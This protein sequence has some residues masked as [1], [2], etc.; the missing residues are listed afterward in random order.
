[1]SRHIRIPFLLDVY[2]VTSSHLILQ[3]ANNPD[4]DRNYVYR[5]PLINRLII[6]RI[7]A[8]MRV[9][10][11]I[12]DDP[13]KN[14]KKKPHLKTIFNPGN[15][16]TNQWFPSAD[17]LKDPTRINNRDSLE[18]RLNTG[19][20][21]DSNLIQ[22][23]ARYIRNEKS[24]P[25]EQIAQELVGRLFVGDFTANKQ[26]IKYADRIN[27]AINSFNPLR[28]I[29]WIATR[30]LDR[31]HSELLISM[32]GDLS[33]VHAISIAFHNITKSI[34]IMASLYAG[35]HPDASLDEIRARAMHAPESVLRQSKSVSSSQ[36]GPLRPGTLV[37]FS[38]HMA[39][40]RHL[41]NRIAFM[42]TSPSKCPAHNAVPN[43]LD[44]IW[45]E[46][47]L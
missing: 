36:I 6:A 8:G 41:D 19:N 43:L 18:K 29:G 24:R 34:Q 21:W 23:A 37:V 1:M 17:A 32:N 7:K 13:H 20:V 16:T 30:G 44:Q 9:K 10:K 12:F 5:G 31:A 39:A 33:G 4:L 47:M 2:R 27:S 3:E 22:E 14:T 11:L 35:S 45:T 15:R 40:K 46:V 25:A 42:S 26:S 28:W 38:A